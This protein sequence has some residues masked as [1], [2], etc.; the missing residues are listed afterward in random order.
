[1]FY[2]TPR[3]RIKMPSHTTQRRELDSSFARLPRRNSDKKNTTNS[4]VCCCSSPTP[5]GPC[6]ATTKTVAG[7]QLTADIVKQLAAAY[8]DATTPAP[9]PVTK[10][11]LLGKTRFALNSAAWLV[12]AGVAVTAYFQREQIAEA[13]NQQLSAVRSGLSTTGD[14]ASTEPADKDREQELAGNRT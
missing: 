13:A 6:L 11:R 1:M 3:A 7:S 10:R 12:T 2:N 14:P 5:P 8:A 9:A 4:L